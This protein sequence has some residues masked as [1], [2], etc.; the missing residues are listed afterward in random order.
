MAAR[1]SVITLSRDAR[2]KETANML[3]HPL[4]GGEIGRSNEPSQ[5]LVLV[6]QVIGADGIA[7]SIE[8]VRGHGGPVGADRAKWNERFEA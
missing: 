3:P 5:R 7:E 2:A 1:E 8:R 4:F 6:R